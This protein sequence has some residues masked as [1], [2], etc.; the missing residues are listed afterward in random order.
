MKKV[1]GVII[2]LTL[3]GF[4]CFECYYYNKNKESNTLE[5]TNDIT[6]HYNN[7]V[8]TNKEAILYKLENNNYV[9][10]GKVNIGIYLVLEDV[11]ESNKSNQ[12]FHLRDIDYY[13]YYKD[14]NPTEKKEFDTRYKRYV[15][16]NENVVTKSKTIFYD[17]NNYQIELN[18]GIN[19]P[20]WIIDS[21]KYYV[22]YMG[23]LLYVKKNN[24]KEVVKVN[25]TNEKVRTSIRTLT[26]HQV[27]NVGEKCTTNS[28]ICHPFSQ[29]EAHFKYLNENNYLTLTM[30]ELEK[31]LDGKIRIPTKS[32]VITFDDGAKA[33]NSVNLATKYGVNITYFII[34]GNYNLSKFIYNNYV[35][36][37]SHTDS[38]HNNYR[39]PGGNQGGQLLCEDKDIILADLALSQEKLGG[40]TNVYAFAYPFF[41]FNERAIGLLKQSGFRLAFI[42]QYGAD[43][44]SY[45]STNRYMLRR[46]TIFS[47]DSLSTF[48]SYLK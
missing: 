26:Y 31:F 21:D 45:P 44:Y 16:F 40:K 35:D 29:L 5:N 24:V 33:Y 18:E 27:Y 2:L 11:N 13:I 4:I 22:E 19:L 47:Y 15:V 39:C 30:S 36:Y 25:N 8:I 46:K 9:E 42:G 12:Y 6:S 37:Q 41:D 32:I 28:A 20:I 48:I 1:L 10:S 23:R 34:T 17:N 3:I 43:G 38:L 7:S 14:V